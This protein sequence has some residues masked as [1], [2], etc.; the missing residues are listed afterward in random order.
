MLDRKLSCGSSPIFAKFGV[1]VSAAIVQYTPTYIYIMYLY[2]YSV[3]KF[4]AQKMI[5]IY[6]YMYVYTYILFFTN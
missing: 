6:I 2:I 1:A 3:S 5:Y 4:I